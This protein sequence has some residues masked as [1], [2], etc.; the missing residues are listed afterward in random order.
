MP[1]D[2]ARSRAYRWGEDGIGGIC[3]RHQF[4]C[5]AVALWNG[6]D[7]ILKERFFGLSGNEGNH[8]EDV[9]EYYYFLDSTP[10]H[11]YMKFLYKYPQQAFP[12]DQLLE[13]NR[14]RGK[15]EFEYELMDTGIFNENRYFDVYVEYAKST[16]ED[17]LIRIEVINRSSEPAEIDILPTMW[18]RDTWSWGLD[19]RRPYAK[20]SG[21]VGNSKVVHLNQ[22]YYGDRWL[23]C[24]GNPDLLFTHNETNK[25][26]LWNIPNDSNFVKDGI[27]SYIVHGNKEAVNRAQYGT[28]MSPHY[29]AIL[30]PGEKSLIRLRFSNSQFSEDNKPFEDY[31]RIFADRIQEAD[32]FYESD[33]SARSCA[34]MPGM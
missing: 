7:P 29:H 33:D 2:Q 22:D 13:E 10:T 6:K 19:I 4:I 3:D 11:S 27:D 30:Q 26:R 14:R 8:G 32:E 21:I 34:K 20:E 24:E 12:Y 9:K 17:I 5:F 18:F 15:Q 23:Y 25:E 31:D 16:S 28:K 1:H